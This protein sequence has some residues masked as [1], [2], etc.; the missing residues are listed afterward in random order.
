MSPDAS[1]RETDEACR[2]LFTNCKPSR[3][4]SIVQ[5]YARNNTVWH[6]DFGGAYQILLEHGYPANHLVAA[7]EKLPQRID[8]QVV[9]PSVVSIRLKFMF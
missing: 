9:P 6:E 3:T 7:G 1:G 2:N 4:A 8:P 5:E